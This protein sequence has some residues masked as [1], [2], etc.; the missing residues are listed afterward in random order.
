MLNACPFAVILLSAVLLTGCASSGP[1][2]VRVW[3]DGNQP[4]PQTLLA[5]EQYSQ[6][7]A[8]YLMS[9]Q[10]PPPMQQV[11]V[12]QPT[13]ATEYEGE[14]TSCGFSTCKVALRETNW[15][16]LNRE[17][18]KT[19]DTLSQNAYNAGYAIGQAISRSVQ[20]AEANKAKKQKYGECLQAAGYQQV[21]LVVQN[22]PLEPRD[23]KW[24]NFY[25]GGYG[26]IRLGMS[27]SDVSRIMRSPPFSQEQT[28]YGS[29]HQYCLTG[30]TSD[31]YFV[32][33]FENGKVIQKSTYQVSFDDL[34]AS[35]T[36]AT[37]HCS[38]FFKQGNY[39]PYDPPVTAGSSSS[40]AVKNGEAAQPPDAV[41]SNIYIGQRK[42]GV[43]HG[44]GTQNYASGDKY[45]GNWRNDLEHGEGAYFYSDGRVYE[46]T[47]VNGQLDG[48]VTQTFPSGEVYQGFMANGE[49]D[50]VGV[51]TC[52]DGSSFDFYY[53][54]G[55][56]VSGTYCP[57]SS[58]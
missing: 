30:Q 34:V 11:V 56:R 50:G 14:I 3:K 23:P 22:Y 20:Q 19:G 44:I 13:V 8:G 55:K 37:G 10:T 26:E 9:N 27:A 47:W 2:T 51:L 42:N 7:V 53:E 32:V 41:P 39:K 6:L 54:N 52:P 17:M 18:Q 16:R 45:Y 15:S 21:S 1:Q 28:W 4:D 12:I 24:A 35:G 43:R 25:A 29:E 36:V 48:Y 31:V 46:G 38:Y 33:R 49:L 57:K 58:Y 40:Q 5:C